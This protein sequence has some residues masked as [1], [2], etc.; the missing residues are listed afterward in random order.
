[1]IIYKATNKING[2]IYIGQAVDTL[3]RRK[4]EHLSKSN[5]GSR[6]YFH[7]ALRKYGVDGFTW[8]IIQVCKDI[9]ELNKQEVYYIAFY[10]SFKNGYNMTRG[11]KNCLLSDE[12]K[13]KLS[14]NNARHWLGKKFSEK[15]KEKMCLAQLGRIFSEEQIE[16]M[17]QAQLGKKHSE[18]HKQKIGENNARY[19]MG[20]HLP[21]TT[22]EKLRQAHLGKKHS[23]ATKKKMSQSSPRLSGND[24]PMWGRVGKDNPN[25]GSKRTEKT[26][27]KMSDA[28]QG[29]KLSIEHKKNISIAKQNMS[30][31]TK[32]KM[33]IA[34]QKRRERENATQKR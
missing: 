7:R 29:M 24:N 10:D 26:K 2:K 1:M 34:Q 15:H 6:F 27:K 17:R 33:R 25:Y 32:Q 12:I 13:Q 14:D 18:E 28:R 8:E 23:E 19:W 11:G 5:N 16:N 3:A 30:D 31:A 21:E 22:K 4:T 20:K 9:D